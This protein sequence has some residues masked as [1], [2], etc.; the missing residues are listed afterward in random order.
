[1]IAADNAVAAQN[2]QE[3]LA[4][5]KYLRLQSLLFYG[6]SFCVLLAHFSKILHMLEKT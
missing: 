6:Q 3:K 5:R 4:L 1:M 2:R